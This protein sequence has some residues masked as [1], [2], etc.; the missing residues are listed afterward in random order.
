MLSPTLFYIPTTVC[1]Y[2]LAKLLSLVNRCHISNDT[3]TKMISVHA[4]LRIMA[5]SLHEK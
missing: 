3:P 4:S 5:M 1:V 2:G